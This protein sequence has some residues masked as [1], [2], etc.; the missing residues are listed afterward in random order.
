MKIRSIFS[1]LAILA[2]ASIAVAV[3]VPEPLEAA[4]PYF[5][6][7]YAKIKIVNSGYETIADSLRVGKTA[8]FDGAIDL[9]PTYAMGQDAFLADA[10]TDTV[11]ITGAS[12]TDKYI[13]TPYATG[14][15]D[16][17]GVFMVQPTATGFVLHRAAAAA[18][19]NQGYTWLRSK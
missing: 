12:A 15:K 5:S 4:G 18:E 16:S 7:L 14:A 6:S 3:F 17:V 8:T 1:V 10:A 11:T 19:A 2:L 13:V 9:S